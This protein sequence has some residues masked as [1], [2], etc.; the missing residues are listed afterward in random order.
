MLTQT[1]CPMPVFSKLTCLD[2]QATSFQEGA[3][4]SEIRDEPLEFAVALGGIGNA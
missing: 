2:R 3:Y 4:F 1:C